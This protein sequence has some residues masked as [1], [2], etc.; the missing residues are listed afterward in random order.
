MAHE[1]PLLCTLLQ[2]HLS[3]LGKPADQ[4]EQGFM[5]GV[6]QGYQFDPLQHAASA[7]RFT[8]QAMCSHLPLA[9]KPTQA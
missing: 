8:E 4:S 1:C 3:A 5:S 9:E 2:V 6:H 7:H